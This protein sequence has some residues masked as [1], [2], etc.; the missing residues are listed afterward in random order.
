MNYLPFKI[1]YPKILF[2]E[3]HAV[4]VILLH[5]QIKHYLTILQINLNVERGIKIP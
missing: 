5:G 3:K 4:I 2:T 1:L